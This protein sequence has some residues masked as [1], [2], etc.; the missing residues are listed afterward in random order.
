MKQIWSLALALGVCVVPPAWGFGFICC[1]KGIH[2]L[3][4]LPT[5]CDGCGCPCADGHHRCSPRKAARA[6]ALVAQLCAPGC[7]E[8]IEAARKLAH[9][10]NGDFC[11]DP[12]IEPA[13]IRALLCDTCWEVRRAAGW[14]LAM[15][16]DRNSTVIVALYV[17][18]KMDPHYLVRDRAKEAIDILLICRRDCFKDLFG[19]FGDDLI[20]ALKKAKFKPGSD[21]CML[22]YDEGCAGCGIVGGI[23]SG[24]D[25]PA[26]PAGPSA[27]PAPE[28]LPAPAPRPS[29]GPK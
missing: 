15:Q 21:N 18:S 10:W 1:N 14:S 20:K 29:P 6:N 24:T 28:L 4:Q 2:C 5:P 7:C 22:A 11:C 17:S 3:P 12:E 19:T 26:L 25:V 13:L 9:R 23:V 16:G 27:V 8:R